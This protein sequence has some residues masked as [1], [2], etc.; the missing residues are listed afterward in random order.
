MAAAALRPDLQEV[1][2]T[3]TGPAAEAEAAGTAAAVATAAGLAVEVA[4]AGTGAAEVTGV[5]P[6]AEVVGTAAEA[7]L[8]AEGEAGAVADSVAGDSAMRKPEVLFPTE[9]KIM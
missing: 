7:T 2:V 6:V 1:A 5:G 4:A 3:E 8:A 9:R